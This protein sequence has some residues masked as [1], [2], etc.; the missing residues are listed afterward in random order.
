MTNLI[1]IKKAF[2]VDPSTLPHRLPDTE[3]DPM[4]VM[5][6]WSNRNINLSPNSAASFSVVRNATAPLVDAL[7]DSNIFDFVCRQQAVEAV[8]AYLKNERNQ[9]GQYPMTNRECQMLRNNEFLN[10]FD[11]SK[12]LGHSKF[13]NESDVSHLINQIDTT[14]VATD[15]Q[16]KGLETSTIIKTVNAA[17]ANTSCK[18]TQNALKTLGLLSS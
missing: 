13:K 4:K 1:D 15:R 12:D 17:R 16:K 9:K 6:F 7:I 14:Y 5:A 11:I 10:N 18:K 3:K 2:N 8:H